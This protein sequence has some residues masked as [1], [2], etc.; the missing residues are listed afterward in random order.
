MN[1]FDALYFGKSWIDHGGWM[2]SWFWSG[3]GR[4]KTFW[5]MKKLDYDSWKWLWFYFGGLLYYKYTLRH[6][7]KNHTCGLGMVLWPVFN[8]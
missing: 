8:V 1:N 5:L 2:K 3:E 7:V 4:K 6:E